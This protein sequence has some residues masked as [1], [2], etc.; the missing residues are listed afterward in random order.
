[1]SKQAMKVLQKCINPDCGKTFGLSEVLHG[2][3]ECGNLLDASYE[4]SKISVPELTEFSKRCG[5]RD[6]VLNRSGVW[7]FRELLPFDNGNNVVTMAEA[8]TGPFRSDA[9]AKFLSKM[10][11]TDFI[12]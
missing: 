5:Q 9:M 1:M 6:N 3:T 11:A 4:W 10:Y 8:N 2:C 7:R 12:S